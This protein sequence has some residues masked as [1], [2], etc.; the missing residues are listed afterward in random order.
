MEFDEALQWL[1][2]GDDWDSVKILSQCAF[3]WEFIDIGEPVGGGAEITI[4]ELDIQAPRHILDKI[5]TNF[6]SQMEAI[7][8]AIY[9]CSQSR[10]EYIRAIH[11]VPK[12]DIMGISPSDTENENILNS[13]DSDQVKSAWAKA[14]QRRSVDPAGAI[15]SANTLLDSVCKR[16][17]TEAG[18]P[19]NPDINEIYHIA[20]EYLQLSPNQYTDKNL[21]RI[22]G[23]CEA[24]VS[25]IAF[26]R[27][28]F[29]DAHS[30]SE[31]APLPNI[32]LAE[33]TVN[34]AGTISTFLARTWQEKKAS[35]NKTNLE[36]K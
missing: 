16:I 33:L 6:H 20:S 27:N 5:T 18:Y 22:L 36:N 26:I 31:G 30:T 29:G 24:V 21:K 9:E 2:D 4:L 7:E 17:L 25:G 32:A 15:T 10:H 13:L 23:N 34:L 35:N 28:K 14:L 8:H 12:T 11:W 1:R 19:S 3:S